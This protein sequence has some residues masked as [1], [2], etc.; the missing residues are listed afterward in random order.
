MFRY[1]AEATA[2]CRRSMVCGTLAVAAAYVLALSSSPAVGDTQTFCISGTSDGVGW[3]WGIV[4][5][6]G[7][8]C[9][10]KFEGPLPRGADCE[11]FARQFVEMI[12]R[13]CPH[14]KAYLEKEK[15]CFTIVCEG[16]FEFWVGAYGGDP[17]TGKKV[18]GSPDPVPFNP[19]ILQVPTLPTVGIINRATRDLIIEIARFNFRYRAWGRVHLG[20]V[21][22]FIS[23]FIDDGS[24]LP[25]KV[26]DPGHPYVGGEYAIA[27]GFLSTEATL[28]PMS[29][30]AV[31]VPCAESK[32][33][34][35][36]A[37]ASGTT[38]AAAPVTLHTPNDPRCLGAGIYEYDALGARTAGDLKCAGDCDPKTRCAVQSS[39]N[40]H[41]GK[42]EWC[43]CIGEPEEQQHCRVVKIT[44][45]PGE[46]GGP[47]Y[48]ACAGGC[49]DPPDTDICTE[50]RT[51]IEKWPD[52]TPKKE[53]FRCE[54]LKPK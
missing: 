43:G 47:A 12:K 6:G 37:S 16:N 26:I 22:P 33:S 13:I 45:G 38:Q 29:S 18:T 52:G 25:V 5:G 35:A 28:S 39:T 53:V 20:S 9:S 31:C 49:P 27:E 3:S 10:V 21:D 2:R 32:G 51:V 7:L 15:C 30:T 17:S 36:D 50:V 54:C 11:Q 24:L 42:R 41:G 48:F 34:A 44:P 40:A 14:C 8:V 4:Q 23:Y 46:G 1:W 19:L